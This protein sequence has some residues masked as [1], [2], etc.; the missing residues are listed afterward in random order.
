[1]KYTTNY[2][3]KKP[4]GGDYY[5]V[6]DQNDNMEAIDQALAGL[7]SGKA[8]LGGDG[9]IPADQ[10]PGGAVETA[11]SGAG[12]KSAPAD[13]DSVALVD[14][15]DG[16]KL[17]RVLWSGVKSALKGYFDAVYAALAHSHA[18][19]EITSGTLASARLPTVPISKGGTGAATA[20]AARTALSVAAES[21]T[22]SIAEVTSL[23]ST[24]DGKAAAS[25][26][27]SASNITSGTL[28]VARGG[29]EHT[30]LT[31]TTYTAARY[32][33]SALVSAEAAPTINGVINW[34][35]E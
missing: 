2:Q 17:K 12:A 29:T 14:S 35:Y 22:H 8:D 15:A 7:E 31:D 27:H 34:T 9:K 33:A 1:M 26:N 18:A 23:Q 10:V 25:H 16:N 20:E 11:I 6:Q 32:R 21:H 28:P 13:G 19:G 4:E 30:S 5:N 24:L 3:L